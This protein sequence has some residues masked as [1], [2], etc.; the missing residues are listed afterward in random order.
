MADMAE[1][2]VGLRAI[3]QTKSWAS[4]TVDRV[5]S[6]MMLKKIKASAAERGHSGSAGEGNSDYYTT[7]ALKVRRLLRQH[8][9]IVAAFRQL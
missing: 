5:R 2:A 7:E 8:S 9:D 1:A 6:R 3:F 4:R